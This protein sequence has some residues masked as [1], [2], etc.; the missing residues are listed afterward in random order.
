MKIREKDWG[1]QACQL[2][3]GRVWINK[4][5]TY[6]VT[7]ASYWWERFAAAALVRLCHYVAGNQHPLDILSYVDDHIMLAADKM[8]IIL[9]GTLIFFLSALGV[10]WHWGKGRGGTEVDWIGYWVDLW[11][12]RLGIS[13]RR[14][15]WLAE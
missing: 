13:V 3:A 12:G 15:Q 8:G 5:G 9:C 1:Y 11:K 10:P 14:A 6:G 4:V 7:S 2:E